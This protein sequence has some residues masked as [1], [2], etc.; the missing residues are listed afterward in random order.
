MTW[1]G[2]S[3]SAPLPISAR[4]STVWLA[5]STARPMAISLPVTSLLAIFTALP[6]RSVAAMADRRLDFQP[7]RAE[8]GDA[9]DQRRGFDALAELG[10]LFE[11]NAV[12]R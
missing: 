2:R 8:F 3:V 6:S 10:A 1:P 12:D 4:S 5:G 7:Q 11:H 9:V